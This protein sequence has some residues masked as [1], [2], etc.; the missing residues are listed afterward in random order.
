MLIFGLMG[1]HT[2]I[3]LLTCAEELLNISEGEGGQKEQLRQTWG[4]KEKTGT[5]FIK[6]KSE[7]SVKK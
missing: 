2:S 5:L 3:F 7:K 6:Q 1:W 4:K